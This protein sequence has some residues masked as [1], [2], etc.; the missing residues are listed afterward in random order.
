[1]ALARRSSLIP[2]GVTV[3][4]VNGTQHVPKTGW[5]HQDNTSETSRPY[6]DP[7]DY[8]IPKGERI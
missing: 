5:D 4:T 2:K 8:R 7:R 1:M 3:Q 6:T